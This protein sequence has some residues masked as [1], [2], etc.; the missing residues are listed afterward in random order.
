MILRLLLPFRVESPISL[1]PETPVFTKSDTSV[2][3]VQQ[4]SYWPDELPEYV[5]SQAGA[6]SEK[7]V[8]DYFEIATMV[9]SAVAAGMLLYTLITYIRLKHRVRQ[10]IK[11][12]NNIYECSN[13]DTPFLLG[14]ICPKI[15]LPKGMTAQNAELV[16]AHERNHIR[17][18]DNWFKLISFICL[19]LHWFNPI[20][21]VAYMLICKD[22]EDA[23]D[24]MVVKELDDEGRRA[25]STALLSCGKGKRSLAACPVAFGETSIRQRIMNVLHYKKPALW[26]S[27]VVIVLIAVVTVFF[28]TDP[29]TQKP[30]YYE[31]LLKSIG[32]PIETVC[33]NMGITRD[34]LEMIDPD[35]NSVYR[36]N[37]AVTYMDVSFDLVLSCQARTGIF[38]RFDYIAQIPGDREKA[39][40]AAAQ[41][42]QQCLEAF[43]EPAQETNGMDTVSVT[44]VTAEKL[45][46]IY[47]V[48]RR[49]GTMQALWQI[50]DTVPQ[51]TIDYLLKYRETEAW[52]GMH[53]RPVLMYPEMGMWLTTS[54]DL[55]TDVITIQIKVS[56][57]V[58]GKNRYTP[59]PERTW[60]DKVQDW[61]N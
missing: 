52:K 2:F 59:Y 1:R 27:L 36:L 53:D 44:G 49:P 40:T 46:E 28:M 4:Q 9:W 20:I 15:Y 3:D 54:R 58:A 50:T 32:Q 43:G 19:S 6:N 25:Y 18:G 30:P 12:E 35:Y 23:C 33:E 13:L 45:V 56:T 26:I 61:L 48:E 21:W 38:Y 10:A 11:I 5:P 41:I 47:N 37:S 7:V 60:W 24:E 22:I 51:E 34:A 8:V 31:E 39:A 42:G 29:V 55:E 57:G 17:R 14:Y 16:I